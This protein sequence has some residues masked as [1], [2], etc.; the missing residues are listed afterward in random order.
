MLR[1]HQF[2][3]RVER[4]MFRKQERNVLNRKLIGFDVEYGIHVPCETGFF[5]FL[6][7]TYQYTHRRKF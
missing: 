3:L 2:P 4:H 5:T 7:S 6:T 1:K